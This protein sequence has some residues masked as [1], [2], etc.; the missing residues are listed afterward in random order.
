MRAALA[1][2]FFSF[3]AIAADRTIQV[4]GSCDMEVTPDKGRVTFQA[5]NQSKDQTE[6]VNKTN[7]QINKLKEEITALKLSAVELKTTNY[8]VHPVKEYEKD[9]YVD[10]G[11]RAILALE[12]SSS[13]I[14]KLGETLALASKI[15]IQNVGQLQTYL[16]I[17]KNKAEYLKCLDI[18]S[19]DARKKAEQIAKKL[20]FKIGDV[21]SILESPGTSPSPTPVFALMERSAKMDSTQV[22][23]GTQQFSTQLQVSFL[24][25]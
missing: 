11:T 16:S 19:E 13:D 1:L 5:E 21:F 10:K 12:V 15:G 18:A 20:G 2:I 17:E 8:Q 14:T 23:A 22:E 24:I 3:S 4:Q 25:K 6:A 7:R 9:K